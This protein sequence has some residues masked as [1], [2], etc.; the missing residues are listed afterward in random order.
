MQATVTALEHLLCAVGDPVAE[1]RGIGPGHAE[2]E[3]AQVIRAAA[4]VLA[5]SPDALPALERV[6]HASD[7]CA[8]TPEFRAHLDAAAAWLAADPVAAGE[9]YAAILG[10]SPHDLLALRL[11]Q[12]CYFFLGRHDQLCAVI[13]AIAPAWRRDRRDFPFVLAMASFAHAENG[14]AERAEALG[15]Q[16]LAHNPACPMGVHAVAH[17]IA[18]SG[19]HDRGAQ[20]MREQSLHWAGDSRMRSHNAWHLALFDVEDG[21]PASALGI[22]D[23]WLMPASA[24]SPLDACD[25][26]ALLWRLSLCGVDAA[27]RWA[28]ISDAFERDSTPGF[29]PYVDLHAGLAHLSAGKFGCA[30]RLGRALARCARGASHAAARARSVTLPGL[31]ALG[32]WAKRRYGDAA[33]LLAALQPRICEAGG[34]RFQLELFRSIGNEAAR[35]HRSLRPVAPAPAPTL[36]IGSAVASLSGLTALQS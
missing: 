7:A 13:D 34:S 12:S 29:W 8:S 19:R 6:L 5:K 25:A 32:A 30:R 16:A 31:A 18:E 36:P 17:A 1:L 22:L 4:C 14:D 26:A 33:R 35:L 2:F 21:D 24:H 23:A 20:W 15:R 11:A 28:K 9:R 3:R 27:E 10:R